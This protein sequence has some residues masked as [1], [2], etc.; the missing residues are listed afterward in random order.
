MR[1][2]RLL[3][4]PALALLPA[5]VRAQL[6]TLVRNR[7]DGAGCA[8]LSSV[9]DCFAGLTISKAGDATLTSASSTPLC[10]AA[11]LH[12]SASGAASYYGVD[13]QLSGAFVGRPGVG[14]FVIA[15]RTHTSGR[16]RAHTSGRPPPQT[17]GLGTTVTLTGL[18]S[19]TAVY[20]ITQGACYGGASGAVIAGITVAMFLLVVALP[21]L[22]VYCGCCACGR[23]RGGAASAPSP[24][25]AAVIAA[26]AAPALYVNPMGVSPKGG[27]RLQSPQ[28]QQAQLQTAVQQASLL[29]QA[30]LQL[31]LEQLRLQLAALE[32]PRMR[33]QAP[34]SATTPHDAAVQQLL[35]LQA[36]IAAGAP[37]Q[38]SG[39]PP[40]PSPGTVAAV[41]HFQAQVQA[42][43]V[44]A[45][46]AQAA[47][48]P[49]R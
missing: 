8:A 49:P 30:Q 48:A 14:R 28:A 39:A 22:L 17:T 32:D 10:A 26:A 7:L 44:A 24:S 47:A 27:P 45:L 34:G 37:P 23:P 43:L 33:A 16:A 29:R 9:T 38:P 5:V 41:Q 25:H 36:S 19:C 15:S 3:C 12:V 46:L 20:T 11:T 1:G 18:Q 42:Q 35:A 31:Q 4:L 2:A 13:L 6:C 40:P 21:V